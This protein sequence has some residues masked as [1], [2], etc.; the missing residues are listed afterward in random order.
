[1]LRKVYA[2]PTSLTLGTALLIVFVGMVLVSLAWT[3][4]DPARIDVARRLTPPGDD[5]HLLGTD[6]MG[7]DMLSQIMAGAQNS[8]LVSVVSTVAA[9]I[10][11]VVFGLLVA[12][13]RPRWQN[14]LSRLVDL[15][16]ALPGILVALVLATAIGPG[17]A[18][19]IIA[20]IAS[21]IPIATRAVIGPARQ[22]LTRDYVEA[23]SAYGRS[24]H[25]VLARHVLPNI[26]P[27]VI[28]LASVMFA[29][30]I[31]V[32]AALAYLGVGAQ[33]P[34]ASWGRMLNEA[35]TLIDVAPSLTIFPGIAIVIAVLGF[36][37]VG[38]GLRTV[39]DP[40]QHAR[41]VAP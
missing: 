6:Q 18:T 16:I 29:S 4:F 37:L 10:P 19:A 39:L 30:A 22:I 36:N 17:N 24:R 28:V 14:A 31:L 32:E 5:G 23:A 12:G 25:Y 15:G 26:M 20:I 13:S 27:L 2:A 3:P 11:G 8:L 21:F 33:P 7:R 35:Q 34:T 9:V 38:D 40:Q 41:Q 1:M